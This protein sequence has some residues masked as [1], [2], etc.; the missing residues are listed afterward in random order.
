MTY[1]EKLIQDNGGTQRAE[2]SKLKVIR[3]KSDKIETKD[4]EL[5]GLSGDVDALLMIPQEDTKTKTGKPWLKG[6][7]V[8]VDVQE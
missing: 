1:I 4:I 8:L 5:F 3:I 2:F 6:H 7:W